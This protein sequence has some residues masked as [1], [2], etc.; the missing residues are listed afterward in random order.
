M[1]CFGIP[2]PDPAAGQLQHDAHVPRGTGRWPPCH[3]GPTD[4]N[5]SLLGRIFPGPSS[6]PIVMSDLWHVTAA[7]HK[8]ETIEAS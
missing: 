4:T 7:L 5:I 6:I 2:G 3:P 8:A 1:K